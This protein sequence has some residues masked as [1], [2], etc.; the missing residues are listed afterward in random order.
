[1]LLPIFRIRMNWS[2]TA[3]FAV[4]LLVFGCVPEQKE[5]L[6]DV[7]LH[8]ADPIFQK[9][10]A[11]QDEQNIDSIRPFFRHEDATYRYLS[12]RACASIQDT[13]VID[14]LVVLLS[15]PVAE[16]R[17]MAAFA[18]GQLRNNRVEKDLIAA[19]DTRDSSNAFHIP[20]EYILEALGKCG[21][22]STLDLLTQ[23]KSYSTKD[24]VLLMGQTR[25]IYQ[26]AL[27]GMTDSLGTARMIEYI[28][29]DLYPKSVK[30]MAANY[31][32]R[33][34]GIKLGQYDGLIKRSFLTEKDPFIRSCLAIALGKSGT[35]ASKNYLIRA[36]Q[37]EPDNRVKCNLLRGLSQYK[38]PSL[39]T[40]AVEFMNDSDR[41]VAE[42][43][44]DLLY[45][46][47]D[48]EKAREYKLMA[49]D[50]NLH[51]MTRARLYGAS[52][53]CLPFYYTISKNSLNYDLT[54]WMSIEK[55]PI[56]RAQIVNALAED[57][58][59]YTAILEHMSDD[60]KLV[61]TTAVSAFGKI[62]N[63]HEF[64]IVIGPFQRTFFRKLFETVE[65][66]F[67]AGDAGV[68]A[69]LSNW[70]SSKKI[71]EQD[72]VSDKLKYL[73]TVLLKMPI[74]DQIETYNMLA[75]SIAKI[76]GQKKAETKKPPFGHPINL[77]I[78]SVLSDSLSKAIIET[79]KGSFTIDFY[80]NDA[81]SSVV[82]FVD[83]AERDYYDGKNFHRVVPNFVVQGGCSRGDGY[84]SLNYTIRSELTDLRYDDEGWVGMASAGNHTEC[85][86]WF[87]THSPTPHLDGRYTI[88]GKVVDG[89][90]IVHKIEVGDIIKNV[91]IVK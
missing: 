59:N 8:I 17:S 30:W 84:G 56:V 83:L 19:F 15:D 51:K 34:N 20:N 71:L 62:L 82:N 26:F 61:A 46:N 77:E 18:I 42:C 28:K 32:Q 29:G 87:V 24:T 80:L 3:I 43:A 23:V 75:A 35:S 12:S 78:L 91:E 64:D 69:E 57:P 38:D 74:P 1:M 7:E 13:V 70:I 65:V 4:V 73:D 76:K 53:K 90:D 45:K 25:A 66:L 37:D 58:K 49:R 72:E 86:Q 81:P 31:L 48:T 14:D 52:H 63:H 79:N 88:F 22:K 11:F 89:M 47:A 41:K 5:S 39:S 6:D 27:R 21:S 67:K 54:Q 2:L 68:V 33:A 44:L 9:I 16:V 10:I 50:T 40:V 36:L 85:T 55:D 60:N